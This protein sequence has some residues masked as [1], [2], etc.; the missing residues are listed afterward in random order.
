MR[1]PQSTSLEFYLKNKNCS[2]IVK[3][4]ISIR[5]HLDNCRVCWREWNHLRWEAAKSSRGFQE[6]QSYLGKSFKWYFDA[7]WALAQEWNKRK[8]KTFKEIED[9]YANS[10]NYLYSLTLWHESGDRR[11][12]IQDFIKLDKKLGI[13]SCLD[14]GCGIGSDGLEMLRLGK[15]FF[16]T[17]L[18]ILQ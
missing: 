6:L 3:K 12:Y 14:Y 2:F 17:I 18:I 16:S 11:N 8:P 4:I 5:N 10:E 15:K 9:F 13:R 7:S 1:H